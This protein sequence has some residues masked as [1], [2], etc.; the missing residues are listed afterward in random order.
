MKTRALVLAVIFV[1]LGCYQASAAPMRL[2]VL[3]QAGTP[4]PDV[5]VIVKS[6]AGKGEMFR[7]LTDKAGGVPERDLAAGLY[8]AIAT[9]PYGI[10]ETR[11]FEFLVGAVPVNLDL[12]VDVSPTRGNATLVGE[13]NRLRLEVL[14][15]QGMPATSAQVLVRDSNAEFEQWYKT[16]S[17]GKVDVEPR[18]LTTTFAVL[19]KETLTEET[20]DATLI[21]RLRIEGNALVIHLKEMSRTIH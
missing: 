19:Y 8:R 3:D 15:A 1:V 20:I 4:F 6:L 5:L 18:G 21:E 12:K 17:E 2:R 11:I 13:P 14:D 16:D 9:C 10:C 7:A